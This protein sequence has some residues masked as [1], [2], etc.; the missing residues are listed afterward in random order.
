[1]PKLVVKK[2]T[3]RDVLLAKLGNPDRFELR[4]LANDVRKRY[5]QMSP[6]DAYAV[7]AAERGI[8]IH[9]Y[10]T[11]ENVARVRGIM[12]GGVGRAPTQSPR[13]GRQRAPTETRLREIRIG[14]TAFVV[15]DPMVRAAVAV[16]ANQMAE[17]YPLTYTFEN[18]VRELMTRVMER[19][20]GAD[21]WRQPY[22][23]RTVMGHAEQNKKNEAEVP[24]HATRGVHDIHYTAIGD[25]L[26]IMFATNENRPTFEAI[27]GKETSVRHLLEIIEHARH[28]IAHHRPLPK[29][30][31][32][33]LQ[34]NTK[35]W[36]KLMRERGDRVAQVQPVETERTA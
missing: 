10:L 36:Q 11:D 33:R 22:V 28:A 2:P 1:M 5:G 12:A 8:A 13:N 18:S 30:E 32:E 31:R 23:S 24:W 29:D 35:A 6:A 3:L 20:Y 17:I 27:L 19:R 34:L 15:D 14:G 21:W 9:R 16:E 7:L 4:R 26:A 25:L